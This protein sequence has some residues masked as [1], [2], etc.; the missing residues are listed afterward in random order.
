MTAPF[1]GRMAASVI[2]AVPDIRHW[3]GKPESNIEATLF[4]TIFQLKLVITV[5]TCGHQP[6][7]IAPMST[8]ASWCRNAKNR[9]PKT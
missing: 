5:V 3:D 6:T 7:G 4:P 9:T 8:G 2:P 1:Q